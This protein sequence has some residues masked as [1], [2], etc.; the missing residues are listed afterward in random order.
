M[1]FTTP[2]NCSLNACSLN[3]GFDQKPRSN[4]VYFD[5]LQSYTTYCMCIRFYQDLVDL[6]VAIHLQIPHF[7][8]G[9]VRSWVDGSIPRVPRGDSHDEFVHGHKRPVEPTLCIAKL[10]E[11]GKKT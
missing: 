1:K 7:R 8:V 6:Q 2:F 9:T 11:V 5:K 3:V 4:D 10:C